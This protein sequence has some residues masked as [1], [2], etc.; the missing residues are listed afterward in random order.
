MCA[1]V[2][3]RIVFSASRAHHCLCLEARLQSPLYVCD[4]GSV[5]TRF[6]SEKP[7]EI[8]A[9]NMMRDVETEMADH[10]SSGAVW[11]HFFFFAFTRRSFS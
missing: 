10:S 8:E 2:L 1:Y 6:S 11:Y 9:C 4:G 3:C 5:C 7:R